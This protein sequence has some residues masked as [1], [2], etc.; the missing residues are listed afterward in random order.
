MEGVMRVATTLN[1]WFS[2][3]ARPS[4]EFGLSFEEN[5]VFHRCVTFRIPP[6]TQLEVQDMVE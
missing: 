1:D 4:G 3:L 5:S 2:Y 6:R